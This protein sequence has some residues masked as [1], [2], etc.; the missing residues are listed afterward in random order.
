MA[1]LE[2]DLIKL[3]A[4]EPE[5]LDILY[6]WENDSRL[7]SFGSTLAPYSRFA[8]R[9]YI[10]ESRQDIFQVRQLRL[11]IVLKESDAS[12]GTI[13]LYEFD[14]MNLRAGIGIL[15]D[16]NHRQ[17]GIGS[18][19]L[20]LIK[21]YAFKFLLLKQLYAYVPKRNLASQKLFT[22]CGYVQTGILQEWV[23]TQDSFED[24][25]FMQLINSQLKI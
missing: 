5:D 8:L 14:P 12:I 4:L 2:N 6:K 24:V 1:L 19:V 20:N 25:Y 23:K 3:R 10:S 16:E 18:Q 9:E 21:D 7:W 17:K 13:D 15:L 22:R 11:M